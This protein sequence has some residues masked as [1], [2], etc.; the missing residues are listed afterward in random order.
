MCEEDFDVL[1]SAEESIEQWEPE[2]LY[3]EAPMPVPT[4]TPLEE[5]EGGCVIIIDISGEEE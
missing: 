5:D 4:E 2:P 3:I 1:I